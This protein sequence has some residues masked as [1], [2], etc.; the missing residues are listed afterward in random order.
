VD[1]T[2]AL[3]ISPAAGLLGVGLGYLGSRRISTDEREAVARA[4]LRRTVAAYLS[5]LY[6]VVAELRALPDVH[7]G[8]FAQALDRLSGEGA[9]FVRS[10]RE[11]AK[12]GSRPFELSDRLAAAAAN[13]QVLALP[14]PLE[15]AV[16]KANAYV[17]LLGESRSEA[18][19]EQWPQVW[20]G[21][22]SAIRSLPR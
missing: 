21:L 18:L 10:R 7:P 13:L 12:M 17:E 3:I 4:E 22:H 2:V 6:P 14:A 11:I 5:A 1:A 16:A 15:S 19:K 9:A 8:R 20:K